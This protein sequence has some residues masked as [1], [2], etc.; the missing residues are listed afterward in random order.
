VRRRND[1]I[2]GDGASI[3]LPVTGESGGNEELKSP[4]DSIWPAPADMRPSGW[5]VP[6]E[7]PVARRPGPPRRLPAR[8]RGWSVWLLLLV[9]AVQTALSLRLIRAD[10]AF[11]DEALSLW[12]GHLEWAHWLHGA[13]VPPFPKYFS[14][15]PVIYPPL[16]AL[17]DGLGGLAAARVLSL[18]FMLGATVLLWATASRLYGR[19]AALFAAALFAVLGPTL[20]LGAFATFD[21]LRVVLVALAS[22]CVVR[23][24]DRGSATGWMV[25]AGAALA[26][27]DA[28]AYS[29]VLFD[30]VLIALTLLTAWPSGPRLAARRCATLLITVIVMLAAGALAGG[31]AYL[32]GF[33]RTTLVP[34]PSASPPLTVL[35]HS[36]SW[37]GVVMAL[38]ACAVVISW[39]CRAGW[40]QTWLLAVFT[41]AVV[42]GPLEQAREHTLASL[43]EHVGLGAWFG[44]IAAGYAVD[45][46]VAAAPAGRSRTVTCAAC[47]VA[48]VFPVTLGA[49]QSWALAT[50]WPNATSF[51][52]ILRP[53]ADHSSGH[54]LVEDP[55]IARYYLSAGRQWQ[56]WSSTRNIILPSG[57]NTGGPASTSSVADAGNAGVFAEFITHGYFSYVALNFADTT[58][59]D[60]RLAGQLHHDPRYR[61]IA[62]VPYGTEVTPAGQGTYVIWRYEPKR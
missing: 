31:S 44:A 15:A 53:L 41:A 14:G 16:G 43:D 42:L 13:P 54:M 30:L 29:S 52:A 47:V 11:D 1:E 22:W 12:A 7:A 25:A 60:H 34:A 6:V 3:A 32:G 2:L 20:H 17:A 21:A 4:V 40:A 49:S 10:T 57:L 38:G 56:R 48:L 58:A 24:G 26:V 45:R 51:I 50:D 36:T 62:V 19:R 61:T 55:S 35:A 33:A 5:P 46:F 8:E 39:A 28:A 9:L 18:L 23:A 37:A 59:L 27:A